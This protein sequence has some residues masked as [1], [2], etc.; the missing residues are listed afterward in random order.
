VPQSP[1]RSTRSTRVGSQGME[2]LNRNDDDT[3]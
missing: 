1:T 2:S 3:S